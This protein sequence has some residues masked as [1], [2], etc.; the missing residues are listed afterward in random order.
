[1][2]VGARTSDRTQVQK[3]VAGNGDERGVV[4]ILGVAGRRDRRVVRTQPVRL[5]SREVDGVTVELVVEEVVGVRGRRRS[6]CGHREMG[7]ERRCARR[8]QHDASNDDTRYRHM[9]AIG[10]TQRAT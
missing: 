7:T 1:V 3:A 8:K 5:P 6:A 10:V 9:T 2:V 4:T